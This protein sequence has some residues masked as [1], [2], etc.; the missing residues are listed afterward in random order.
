MLFDKLPKCVT[1]A[2]MLLKAISVPKVNRLIKEMMYLWREFYIKTR[3]T[4][5]IKEYIISFYYKDNQLAQFKT[6][7]ITDF[8]KVSEQIKKSR[9][10]K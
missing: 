1:F 10:N 3:I 2:I 4:P 9:I 7:D 5:V 8:L 6:T